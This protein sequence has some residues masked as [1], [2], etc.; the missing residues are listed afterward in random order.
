MVADVRRG[1]TNLVPG[2]AWKN[3]SPGP[4]VVGE[5]GR[6]TFTGRSTSAGV[7]S[8]MWRKRYIILAYTPY[9]PSSFLLRDMSVRSRDEGKRRKTI[10]T[11]PLT[12]P[13]THTTCWPWAIAGGHVYP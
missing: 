1:R 13:T 6:G 12:H 8:H 10:A 3:N 5:G 11:R 7:Y 4:S 2:S 9:P